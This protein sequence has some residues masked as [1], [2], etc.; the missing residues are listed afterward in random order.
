M[1]FAHPLYAGS[2][3]IGLSVS[4]A[5][6]QDVKIGMTGTFTGPNAAIGQN[7]RAAL[8]VADYGYVIEQGEIVIESAAGELAKDPRVAQTY[9]GISRRSGSAA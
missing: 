4:A 9:L 5:V 2:I 7:A 6:A 3:A 8:R 1:G